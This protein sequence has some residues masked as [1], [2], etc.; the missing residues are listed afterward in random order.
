MGLR[1]KIKKKVSKTIKTAAKVVVNKT[2]VVSKAVVNKSVT[3]NIYDAVK[4]GLG[5]VNKFL[6]PGSGFSHLL[7]KSRANLSPSSTKFR[8]LLDSCRRCDSDYLRPKIQKIRNIKK[9]NFRILDHFKPVAKDLVMMRINDWQTMVNL[10]VA[11]SVSIGLQL[12]SSR[13]KMKPGY[14]LYRYYSYNGS[15]WNWVYDSL[16]NWTGNDY[17]HFINETEMELMDAATLLNNQTTTYAKYFEVL[18]DRSIS[19][20]HAASVFTDASDSL[21]AAY[22]VAQYIPIYKRR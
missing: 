18:C 12:C 10:G 7:V 16:V 13:V 4:G 21:H 20:P 2:V 5:N 9:V 1:K 14:R 15:A 6:D 17:V 3:K 8:P 22:K 11:E 19:F